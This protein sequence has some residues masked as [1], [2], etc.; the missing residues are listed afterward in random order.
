MGIFGQHYEKNVA[1][2]TVTKYYYFHGQR[3]AMRKGG[4]L[5]YLVGDHP[6]L[7]SG[8]ASAPPAWS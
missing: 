3:V 1:T 7:H 6:S 8:Q 4:V 2:G 5:Y